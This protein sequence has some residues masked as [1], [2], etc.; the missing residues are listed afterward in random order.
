MLAFIE[1]I[2]FKEFAF[3]Q[4][5]N[6]DMAAQVD[7]NYMYLLYVNVPKSSIVHGN[8]DGIEGIRKVA[9]ALFDKYMSKSAEF[10][11][12]ISY[13]VRKNIIDLEKRG[14]DIDIVALTTVFDRVMDDMFWF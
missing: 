10:E 6:D 1:M 3:E 9:S 11:L 13:K 5:D 2:Q 8:G 12:N 7:M 4:I 14:W